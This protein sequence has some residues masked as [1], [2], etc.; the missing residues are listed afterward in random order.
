MIKKILLLVI[1]FF[2]LPNPIL[3][4]GKND[5]TTCNQTSYCQGNDFILKSNCGFAPQFQYCRQSPNEC[6]PPVTPCFC[7][8][9]VIGECKDGQ[10]VKQPWENVIG[11]INTPKQV[12]NLGFGAGGI[13]TFLT[14]IVT[15]I[16]T[17][18]GI[19]FVFMMILGAFQWITSGGD[20]EGIEKARKRI[21]NA[22][23]GLVLLA[24]TFLIVGVIGQ[25][26]GF[27]LFV[28]QPK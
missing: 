10:Q 5:L 17:I 3:A 13:S 22:I 23:I 4:Q 27:T 21:T 7:T 18:A 2:L 1:L 20:K 15:I 16:Y 24:V 8:Y 14:N 26:T 28:G 19:I 11:T 25:I 12:Q 9:D 6:R